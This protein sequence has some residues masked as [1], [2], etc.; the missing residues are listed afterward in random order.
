MSPQIIS[1]DTCTMCTVEAEHG[2]I[3]TKVLTLICAHVKSQII[4]QSA[5]QCSNSDFSLYGKYE[6]NFPGFP[7]L[8][9]RCYE[10]TPADV[11]QTNVTWTDVFCVPVW[12]QWGWW[13]KR[14]GRCHWYQ[15]FRCWP[16]RWRTSVDFQNPMLWQSASSGEP[17]KNKITNTKTKLK[18]SVYD[19]S[20]GT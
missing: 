11:H 9:V 2:P 10:T 1:E 12:Q 6:I 5:A 15:R 19:A 7:E 13:G 3:D 4:F 17:E 8:L 18:N 16:W 20:T 14:W